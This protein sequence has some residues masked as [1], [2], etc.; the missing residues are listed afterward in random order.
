MV[1]SMVGALTPVLWS[2]RTFR[3]SCPSPLPP[4]K[5]VCMTMSVLLDHKRCLGTFARVGGGISSSSSLRSMGP[6][7][8]S[9]SPRCQVASPGLSAVLI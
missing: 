5:G 7:S 9:G 2:D 6:D 8:V 4:L 1:I 3:G